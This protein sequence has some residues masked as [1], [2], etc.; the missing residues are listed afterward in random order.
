[1]S[2]E[3]AAPVGVRKESFSFLSLQG[4]HCLL[5][6]LKTDTVPATIR[7][8]RILKRPRPG[9]VLWDVADESL[10]PQGISEGEVWLARWLGG[11]LLLHVAEEAGRPGLS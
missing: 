10:D 3:Q 2:F 1:M 6:G 7:G 8:D 4:G 5:C 11:G 9:L